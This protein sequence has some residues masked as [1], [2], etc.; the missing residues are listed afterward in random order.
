M[1]TKS[2]LLAMAFF[3]SLLGSWAQTSCID[4]NG[5]VSSKNQGTTGYYTLNTG[6]EEYAAQT[7]H[8]SGPGKVSQV[9]VYGHY[10]GI[11]GGVPLRVSIF[12][13]DAN[14][15]PTSAL[16][17]ENITWWISNNSTGYMNVIFGGGGVTVN[18]NFAVEI[19][20]RNVSPLGSSFQLQY[21]GDGEGLL[22]DF[23]SLAGTSTGFNWTSAKDNFNKDGDFYL[24][25]K[26]TNFI[27]SDFSASSHCVTTST[28]VVF[29]N[30]T[31]MPKDSMFNTIGLSNYSGAN[32]FYVWNFG[33]SS[34]LSYVESPTHNY[35]TAGVYTVSLTSKID[36]WNGSCSDTHTMQISVGLGVSATSI[37]NV[38]CND[39]NNGSV[40]A[41][42][43]GGA[44][45]YLYSLSESHYQTDPLISNL[46]AGNYTL[47]IKDALGC[48]QTTTFTISEPPAI[49]FT[50][51]GTTNA[52]CG[53]ADGSI[54]VVASG[55]TGAF[56]Y[57]LNFG[58]YQSSGSFSNLHAGPYMVSAKDANG[59]VKW[60]FLN[61]NN[62][63][64]PFLSILSTTNVS[65]NGSHDGSIVLSAT[66][67]SGTLQYSI[68]GGTTFQANG[69]FPNDTAGEYSLL[70]KDAAGCVNGRHL[71]I[72]QP[73]VID[74]DV[75]ASSVSCHGGSDGAV[76]VSSV[77]GGIGTSTY[78]I[79]GTTYQ[80][81]PYFQ[82]LSAGTYTVYVKDVASC[83]KT[84]TAIVS[85]PT[86]VSATI[87]FTNESCNLSNDGSIT[88]VGTGGSGNYKYS[89]KDGEFQ[90]T[91]IFTDL[92]AG[93]YKISVEDGLTCPYS[94]FV[95][96]TQPSVIATTNVTG[97]STCG[98][99]NGSILITASGGSGSGY[100]YSFD[101][102]TFN[103][104]GSF[105]GQH[106]GTYYIYIT[107]GSGCENIAPVTIN[108]S[109]GPV[110]TSSSHTNVSC[111]SL[112][113]G[114]ITINTVTGGTGT[115]QYTL[116]GANW[117]TTSSFSGLFAGNYTVTVKDAN[118]CTGTEDITLTEPNAFAINTQVG[119]VLCNGIA[120]GTL[121]ITAA[122][123]SGTMAYSIDGGY[124]FQ[125]SPNFANLN[126]GVYTVLVRDG[127][128]CTGA[129]GI[130]I[131]QPNP[132]VINEGVLNVSCNGAN[133]GAFSIIA[134]GGTGI[135][136]YS[137]NGASY[138][139]LNQFTGLA[140]GT[141]TVYVKDANNCIQTKYITVQEPI[142][143]TL[144]ANVTNVAC[145]GGN[146]GVVDLSV[147]GGMLGYNF[148]WS[149]G[150]TSEDIFNLTA[151]IY[152]VVVT[153]ANGCVKTNSYTISEP[154]LPLII[155]GVVTDASSFGS[156]DG[157]IDITING[158]TTPYAYSW[159]NS[160]TVAD[161]QNLASGTYTINVTDGNNCT[162][163]N[164]FTVSSPLG[165]ANVNNVG[166][167]ILVYPNPANER[168]LVESNGLMIQKLVVMNMLGQV[169]FETQPQNLK[170]EI[171]TTT[172]EQGAY[173]IQIYNDNTVV[174]KKLKII[175]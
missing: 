25:P 96:I 156:T 72:T 150:S 154:A 140:G 101:G 107:D 91:G 79:N 100:Q 116:N 87:T 62:S 111:N 55:G 113:D 90:P 23:A 30:T 135:F 173:F 13:V 53:N 15:R 48:T 146:N 19:E 93:T 120:G 18:N 132:I 175:R 59:C 34:P 66:G 166:E 60:I 143:I 29:T 99:N 149:S 75:T 27:T 147:H 22:E 174:T 129:M 76:N 36:G 20:I 112:N 138:Q 119:N 94:A 32:H 155:N 68:D 17:S 105:T 142:L 38:S 67:G 141:Y 11:I 26:M 63:G 70:V 3:L 33:D 84:A 54:L 158:G 69:N 131:T 78:S 8:Y 123:G 95:T 127:A 58:S 134:S 61:V 157:A 6:Y 152:S 125:S 42:G 151:G 35:S 137:L 163:S 24:V 77:I 103:S 82:G 97:N 73:P 169:V 165:I 37:S 39:G 1:K 102:Q 10:P 121:A 28:S 85:Q 148:V 50:T 153:D 4:L 124:T 145:K 40:T 114:S 110:L 14:G 5:Y 161:L 108:D 71:R 64:A 7:Y 9:R 171:N 45:P 56:Q 12:N 92:E 44:T 167:Q 106:A 136:H 159:S 109:N 104:T 49:V 139:T 16:S 170:C 52:S 46:I 65:C 51:S 128:S 117:Q 130:T 160:S 31:L 86:A 164:Q 172:F 89:I 126:A 98:N 41:V 81:N 168:V 88:I 118:G 21:T 57:K 2:T 115:L 47:H 162:T 74:F 144:H 133:D 80:S 122:G 43:S 83:I